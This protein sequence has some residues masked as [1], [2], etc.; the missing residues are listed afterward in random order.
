M[1]IK[2]LRGSYKTSFEIMSEHLGLDGIDVTLDFVKSKEMT[3]VKS[4]WQNVF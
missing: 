4:I 2:G 3:V 1:K